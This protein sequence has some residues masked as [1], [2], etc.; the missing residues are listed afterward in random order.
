M[1]NEAEII[2]LEILNRQYY[3]PEFYKNNFLQRT[4]RPVSMLLVHPQP[5]NYI[6]HH[7]SW[8]CICA[9]WK[10]L[11]ILRHINSMN[12]IFFCIIYLRKNCFWKKCFAQLWYAENFNLCRVLNFL[13]PNTWNVISLFK[14][15]LVSE[16]FQK[17]KIT[18]KNAVINR[19]HRNHQTKLMK[20]LNGY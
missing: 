14:Y 17:I 19:S 10:Y 16:Y 2:F 4:L 11:S 6:S 12:I 13:F 7:T 1:C 3:F 20:Q 5:R 9:E 15:D 18:R 8:F